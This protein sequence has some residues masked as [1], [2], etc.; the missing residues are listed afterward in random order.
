MLHIPMRLCENPNAAN[1][2]TSPNNANRSRYAH[3]LGWVKWPSQWRGGPDRGGE[4]SGRYWRVMGVGEG[5]KAYQRREGDGG[6]GTLQVR[7]SV[8][9]GK[10]RGL[11][12]GG[13][14]WKCEEVAECYNRPTLGPACSVPE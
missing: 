8:G 9:G 5:R 13:G 12:F 7:D 14:G 11:Q 2:K 1:E 4:G 3:S 6:G 10:V